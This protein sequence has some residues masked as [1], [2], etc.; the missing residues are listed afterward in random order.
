MVNITII[1]II[2]KAFDE[3]FRVNLK[4]GYPHIMEIIDGMALHLQI[5]VQFQL[6]RA[7]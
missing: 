7:F 2:L 4:T 1:D 5:N 3:Q 6:F